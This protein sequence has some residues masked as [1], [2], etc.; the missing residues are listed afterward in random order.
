MFI[1]AVHEV[2]LS[3]EIKQY[4]TSHLNFLIK[5]QLHMFAIYEIFSSRLDN[6]N[7][8]YLV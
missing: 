2:P 7:G 4:D 8:V 6:K 1:A 5:Q 3:N